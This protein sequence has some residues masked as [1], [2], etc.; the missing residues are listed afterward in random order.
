MELAHFVGKHPRCLVIWD[1]GL[2]ATRLENSTICIS[3]RGARLARLDHEDLIEFDAA[4]LR[5]LLKVEQT[6]PSV[7]L[8]ILAGARTRETMPVPGP[9]AFFV[10]DL[11]QSE[12]F[13]LL[14][15]IHPVPVDQILASPRARQFSDRRVTL[16]EVYGCGIATTLVPYVDP[17]ATLAR[18]VRQKLV[19][20]KDRVKARPRSILLQ[21]NGMLV[22]GD[23]VEEISE[24][25]EKTLKAA[26]IFLGSAALGGPQFLT[27]ANVTK[28]LDYHREHLDGRSSVAG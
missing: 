16:P 2:V 3:R 8:E 23:S 11:L 27:V 13:K 10:A 15:H 26:D 19:L 24:T 6:R 20:W 25:I 18:E 17:G 21:N 1:E 14:V 5:E 12:E 28:A 7:E 9:E 4:P 22:L